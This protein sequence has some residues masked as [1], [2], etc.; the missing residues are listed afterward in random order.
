[1]KPLLALLFLLPHL[2]VFV[3]AGI[4]EYRRWQAIDVE[5]RPSFLDYLGRVDTPHAQ[6]RTDVA[7][8]KPRHAPA[9]VPSGTLTLRK[10]HAVGAHRQER[11]A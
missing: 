5:E 11:P 4:Y 8:N 10:Q 7:H 6:P 1:M 9:N 3:G 2:A